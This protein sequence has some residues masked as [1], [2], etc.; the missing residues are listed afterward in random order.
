MLQE[1]NSNYP[2]NVFGRYWMKVPLLVRSVLSGFGVS[3]LG[4]GIWVLLVTYVPI[5]WSVVPMGV[6]LIL[7][8]M[9]FSGKWNPS[10]TQAF[11]RF[12]TRQ[13]NLKRPVWTW[14]LV[15]AF[16]IFIFPYKT[17]KKVKHYNWTC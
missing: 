4:V 13:I 12:C 1:K 9:Y 2:S 15:A 16:F 5:P 11:R 17:N 14:G 10:N 7:Y 3:S 6:I 8:W